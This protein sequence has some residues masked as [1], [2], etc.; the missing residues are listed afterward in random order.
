MLFDGQ[1]QNFARVG[2]GPGTT[3][4]SGPVFLLGAVLLLCFMKV[5][6]VPVLQQSAHRVQQLHAGAHNRHRSRQYCCLALLS[7]RSQAGRTT[8]KLC[9]ASIFFDTVDS[10]YERFC[11]E[12]QISPVTLFPRIDIRFDSCYKRCRDSIEALDTG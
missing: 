10:R 5:V 8:S 7:S 9:K 2:H 12:V 11:E 6:D 1:R 4:Q 3:H